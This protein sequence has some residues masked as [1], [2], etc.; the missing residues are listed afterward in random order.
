M[1][2]SSATISHTF[3]SPGT[4]TVDLR[5]KDSLGET[6]TVS[7]TITVAAALGHTSRPLRTPPDLAHFWPMGESSGSSF[8]DMLDGANATLTGGVTLGEPGGLV[9]DTSTSAAFDG[10]SGAAHA[11]VDLSGTH[12]LTVEFW[13]KW[14]TYGSDDHLA[15]EFTPNFNE[16]AGGFLVDP[17][18]TP[19]SDFAVVDRGGRL[20]QHGLLRT[21][22]RR[23]VALLRVRD[24]HRSDRPKRRSRR[25]WTAKRS[26]TPRPNRAPARGTSPTRRS[27]G[28]P[29]TRARCSAPG[30]CR[31]SRSTKRP[32]PSTILEHYERGENTYF[33]ANTDSAEHRRY[34]R[35][36]PDAD[37]QPGRLVRA[38][39]ITYAYQWQSCNSDGRR[40]RRHRR[41]HRPGVRDLLGRSGND[42]ARPRH[43]HQPGGLAAGD[44][45]GQPRG[46][47]RG[48]QSSSKRRRSP[49]PR[50]SAKRCRRTPGC[51]VAPKRKSATSGNAAT[52]SG[53]E[54]ADITGA[55]EAAYTLAEGDVGKHAARP[56][57]REQRAGLAHRG[58]ASVPRDRSDGRHAREHW[59]PSISGAPREGQ[60]LTANAGSWLGLGTIGYEYQW[61]RCDEYGNSCE[62]ISGAT[63]LDLHPGLRG[64]R[65]RAAGA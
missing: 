59:A 39:P 30:R 15:L 34:G 6:A 38:T 20:A 55:T 10:S 22:E 11:D 14:S 24:Q 43:G 5:V 12:K 35:G 1:R 64:R 28:S 62:N 7:H 31:T 56:G 19:G 52:P 16:H 9:E 36:R 57:R 46:R 42:A 47:T 54:C 44:L 60:T 41:R 45:R 33:L 27:T 58:L 17:D 49:A 61:Q 63:A 40:M 53:G 13:M 21:A 26:P 50:Q 25:T 4:Y 2:G 37:G 8:A 3:S 48:A 32:R 65:T 18:A 23:R 51:G 29:A